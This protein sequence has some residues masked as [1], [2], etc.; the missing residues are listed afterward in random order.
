LQQIRTGLPLANKIAY[1][2]ACDQ[3]FMSKK[4]S[5]FSDF[6]KKA[7]RATG[8]PIVFALAGGVVVL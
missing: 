8:H 7:A 6:A 5:W 4:S 3:K 1:G 2:P